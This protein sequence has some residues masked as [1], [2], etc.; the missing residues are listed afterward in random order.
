MLILVKKLAALKIIKNIACCMQHQLK[1]LETICSSKNLGMIERHY[2]VTRNAKIRL[3][4]CRCQATSELNW[5]PL[6]LSAR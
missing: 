1:D 4:L 5:G 3:Q 6:T 2:T